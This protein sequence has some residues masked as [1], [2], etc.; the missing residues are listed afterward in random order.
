[1]IKNKKTRMEEVARIVSRVLAEDMAYRKMCK[2]PLIEIKN[3][4]PLMVAD[5]TE[6]PAN[7]CYIQPGDARHQIRMYD[8]VR[9]FSADFV[10]LEYLLNNYNLCAAGGAIYKHVTLLHQTGDIDLFFYGIDKFEAE[11]QLVRITNYFADMGFMCLYS[12]NCTT[13]SKNTEIYQ[14]I[15]RIYPTM[16]SIIGGFDLGVCQVLYDG[17]AILATPLGYYCISHRVNIFDTTRRSTSYEARLHKYNYKYRTGILFVSLN[18]ERIKDEIALINR[19][20]ISKY[21]SFYRNRADNL[22]FSSGHNDKSDYEGE[23]NNT[24]YEE[25]NYTH[26]VLDNKESSAVR[27]HADGITVRVPKSFKIY[28][29]G[30]CGFIRVCLT[31]IFS[32]RSYYNHKILNYMKYF[33]RQYLLDILTELKKY[34]TDALQHLNAG[35]TAIIKKVQQYL[36]SKVQPKVDEFNNEIKKHGPLS[37]IVWITENP[38]RQWTSSINPAFAKPA[39]YF[40]P[41]Y[42]IPLQI[43][44]SPQIE[45]LLRL[46]TKHKIGLFSNLSPD[47]LNL[48]FYYLIIN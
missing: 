9:P 30:Y 48:I 20:K 44:V 3:Y 46:L 25:I 5:A 45:T 39:E 23:T 27:W 37:K 19:L 17:K 6:I 29:S 41:G 14:I 18:I 15:H 22:L 11:A 38:G 35:S 8:S 31:T 13:I 2:W 33:E 26:L 12:T 40:Y 10:H 32:P 4:Y 42:C 28:K 16:D 47:T 21:M 43:G 7:F 36:L 24:I 34:H 1:M